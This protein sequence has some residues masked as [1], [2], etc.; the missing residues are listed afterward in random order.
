MLKAAMSAWVFGGMG[1]WNDMGFPGETQ[2]EYEQVSDKLFDLL[3]ESMEAAATSSM[4]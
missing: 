3:N 2:K 4:I 1:S